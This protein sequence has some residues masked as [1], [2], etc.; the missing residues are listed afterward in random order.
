MYPC[1][2]RIAV[3]CWGRAWVCS[4]WP[5]C[6]ARPSRSVRLA[7]GA[8]LRVLAWPGYAEPEV[9]QAFERRHGVRVELTTIDTDEAMWARASRGDEFDVLALNTAELQ[10][11]LDAGLVQALDAA[12][13]PNRHRQLPRFREHA[14]IPGLQRQGKLYAMPYTYAEMGLIYDR[15]RFSAPP[16]SVDALWDPRWRGQVLAYD[17]A[18]HNFSLAAQSLG[19]ASPFRIGAA[20]WAPAANRLI[21]LRRNVLGFYKQPEES[22][23]MF[24]EH[25]AA[26]M[27]ANYGTQQLR[28]LR[29][30]GAEVGYAI[31]REGALAWLDCWALTRGCRDVGL[32]HAWID[33]Q[34]DELAA[35]LLVER[36]G[37]ANTLRVAEGSQGRLV[38]LEPVEDAARRERLWA[39]IRAGRRRFEQLEAGG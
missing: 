24:R 21:E 29:A 32:A 25:G 39:G 30:A 27:F 22:V 38:W 5:R 4:G 34:L 6:R 35:R 20:D 7:A 36:Q 10:R 2:P 9:V 23:Q 13:I 28:L 26:L 15:R 17:G 14:R 12:R 31:P 8:S 11:Y 1:T 37:L 16:A 19:L 18:A 3:S 33:L